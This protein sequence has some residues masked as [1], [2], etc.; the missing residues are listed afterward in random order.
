MGMKASLA[1]NLCRSHRQRMWPVSVVLCPT[2]RWNAFRLRDE[3]FFGEEK[4][5]K[6]FIL[7]ICLNK[8]IACG[9]IVFYAYFIAIKA[10]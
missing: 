3:L 8:V 5:R 1:A 4:K 2:K 7:T 9:L 10:L 6:R